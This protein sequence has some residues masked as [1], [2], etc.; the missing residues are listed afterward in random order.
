[1]T[2]Y[3]FRVIVGLSTLS[4]CINFESLYQFRVIVSISSHCISLISNPNWHCIFFLDFL[5]ISKHRSE[6]SYS[7]QESAYIS[8]FPCHWKEAKKKSFH[9]LDLKNGLDIVYLLHTCKSK[10]KWKL[11]LFFILCI[12][13][14]FEWNLHG[15]KSKTSER[16]SAAQRA[17]ERSGAR[18]QSDQCIPSEWVTDASE[19]ASGRANDRVLYASIL[20]H[21][22]SERI[23]MRLFLW[24]W[25]KKFCFSP[26]AYRDGIPFHWNLT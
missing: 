25:L 10:K 11:I 24:A 20:Y 4:H 16:M 9:I 19:R 17:N 2:S 22:K 1:M 21:F 14:M 18:E 3:Q 23:D 12:L 8:V 5:F 13:C 6:T 26:Y 7:F 15:C